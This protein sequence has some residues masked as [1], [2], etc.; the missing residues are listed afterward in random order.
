MGLLKSHRKPYGKLVPN[1]EA[2]CAGLLASTYRALSRPTVKPGLR[3]P[4]TQIRAGFLQTCFKVA[5]Y[6][7]AL[8][9]A[10][11]VSPL[12]SEEVT[13]IKQKALATAPLFRYTGGA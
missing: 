10:P 1:T 12:Q 2:F 5:H 4:P 9:L 6:Q 8:K 7:L 11:K 13:A 3:I